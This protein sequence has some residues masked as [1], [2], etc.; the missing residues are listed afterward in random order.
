MKHPHWLPGWLLFFS[1]G[2]ALVYE[3]AWQRQFALVFGSSAPATAAVLAAYFAGLGA[4]SLV[5]GRWARRWQRP[6]RAYAI[7][8]GL[9]GVGALLVTPLLRWFE[10]AYPGIVIALE[11]HPGGLVAVRTALVFIALLAPTFCMGGTL[12]LLGQ[13][14]DRGRQHLGQTAG[15]LYVMNTVGAALGALAVPFLLLPAIGLAGTVMLAAAGNGVLG[16]AAWWLDRCTDTP[17]DD[18]GPVVTARRVPVAANAPVAMPVLGPAAISGVVTFA[19][20]VH[21]N[22]AFAQV[23]EN[24]MY[25]F[26]AITAVVILALAVGAQGARLL[27]ARGF[28]PRRLVS[29]AWLLAGLA[30]LVGPPWFLRLTAGLDY[31][32]AG[33]GWTGHAGPLLGLAALVLF[34]PLC[35]LGLALPAIMEAAGRTTQVPAGGVLGRLLAANIAGSV[36]GALAAGFLLPAWLGVWN[37]IFALGTLTFAAGAGLWFQR[38]PT[39]RTLPWAA[40]AGGAWLL[41][42][43][44]L[45]RLDLPRVHLTPGSDDRVIALAE[46]THGITAVVDR[47]GS[48]RLKLNNHYALGGTATTGD[49]RMQTHLP[50]LLHPAPR[51]VALLGLGTGISAGAALHHPVENLVVIELVPEVAAA[52]RA[53]F[54]A[55]NLGVLD[56]PRTTLV[57]DDARHHLRSSAGRFDVIIGDLVVPWRQG[58]GALFTLEQFTA[59]RAALAP[60]GLFCQWL[61]LFQLSAEETAILTRTFLQVFPR[62]WVWRGDF[63]PHEPAIALIGADGGLAPDG[64]VIARRLAAM[65]PDPDNPHLT[66]PGVFW[67]HLVGILEPDDLPAEE[68]RINSENHPWIELLGPLRHGGGRREALFTGLRLEAWLERTATRSRDRMPSLSAAEHSAAR[69][70]RSL[71]RMVRLLTE[72]DNDGARQAQEQ[73]RAMLPDATFRQLFP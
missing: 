73:M 59:A 63:S 40:V 53:H 56:D 2:F 16:L 62:A 21:W 35:L 71:G 14:V 45:S 18:A 27:L 17:R 57:I 3:V 60:G 10:A 54:A 46:G 50:L 48:R 12:P 7:L 55:A 44:L 29:R 33:G 43:L 70:G 61:P 11:G 49:E 72:G 39:G 38:Q 22:R 9:V 15:W 36:A 28:E 42:L 30:V 8:E 34:P 20:Q 25:S 65:T 5:L 1:G 69:G 67:L 6:L 31:L 13:F 19:L 37:G 23:H 51:R 32:P 52:A 4:G 58:E 26:A 41:S 68:T 47:P 66:A 64:S 24:S